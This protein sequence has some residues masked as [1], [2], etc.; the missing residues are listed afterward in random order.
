MTLITTTPFKLY[1]A[2]A[3]DGLVGRWRM[4][5]TGGSPLDIVDD[6]NSITLNYNDT[7]NGVITFQQSP[8][9]GIV[10]TPTNSSIY[11][12]TATSF[13]NIT[14]FTLSNEPLL[15]IKDAITLSCFFQAASG[16][17]GGPSSFFRMM[18][19]WWTAGNSQSSQK[20]YMGLNSSGQPFVTRGNVGVTYAVDH[21]DD[22]PHQITGTWDG[23][24]DGYARLYID[25]SLV[26]TSATTFLGD[27]DGTPNN[28]SVGCGTGGGSF[29]DNCC[30]MTLDHC[31]VY[32]I[33]LTGPE[34]LSD[35]NALK[36]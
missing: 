7:G 18:M 34:I 35:Y 14:G 6:V 19:G 2:E 31:K 32:N 10:T 8:L 25:G 1:F 30:N 12:Q 21:R 9:T 29:T 28:F 24:T 13:G 17:S 5:E 27:V 11:I 15:S 26:A 4:D 33:A 22:A 16:S 3:V 23:D 36:S 20:M